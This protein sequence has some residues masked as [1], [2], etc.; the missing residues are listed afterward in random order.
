MVDPEC[1]YMHN[2]SSKLNMPHVYSGDELSMKGLTDKDYLVCAY[3]A[4][5]FSLTHKKWCQMVVE[6]MVDIQWN[7]EA[8]QKLVIDEDRR[9]LIYA[10]VKAHRNDT[11]T[12]DD[13]IQNKG[14]GLVGLLS[15]SVCFL[16]PHFLFQTYGRYSLVLVRHSQLKLSPRSRSD[17]CTWLALGN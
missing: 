4:N 17:H 1:F 12:F 2:S 8:F 7:H 13:L 14:Q 16:S 10:L 9:Q 5:G 3:W 15:G 6:A 11:T